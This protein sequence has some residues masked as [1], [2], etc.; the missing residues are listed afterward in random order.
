MA[1]ELQPLLRERGLC[2][3]LCTEGAQ[4]D[5][6][7]LDSFQAKSGLAPRPSLWGWV[8]LT[9]NSA[10]V[11]TTSLVLRF[12]LLPLTPAH[13]SGPQKRSQ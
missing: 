12:F 2:R 13:N 7:G 3:A 11:R 6:A 1:G 8:P 4:S 10:G 5:S 9:Q